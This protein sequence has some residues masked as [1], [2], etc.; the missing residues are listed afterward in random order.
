MLQS[1]YGTNIYAVLLCRNCPD[2]PFITVMHFFGCLTVPGPF[3]HSF[4]IDN[5]I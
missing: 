4:G 5:V 3:S 2:A 1:I